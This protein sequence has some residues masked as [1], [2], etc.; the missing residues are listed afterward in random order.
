MT[1]PPMPAMIVLDP[2][3]ADSNA[4]IG[5]ALAINLSNRECRSVP[6]RRLTQS[7]RVALDRRPYEQII[8]R[9][10]AAANPTPPATANEPWP[11]SP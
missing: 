5:T 1:C 3:A 2:S 11:L 4:C 8:R 10:L 7:L 6:P 9:L